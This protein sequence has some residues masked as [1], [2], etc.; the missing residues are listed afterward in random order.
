MHAF[1]ILF[2]NSKWV[3][4][5]YGHVLAGTNSLIV[6]GP[7]LHLVEGAWNNSMIRY[8]L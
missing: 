5:N 8:V 4:R 7:I 3:P 2:N 6:G 1:G